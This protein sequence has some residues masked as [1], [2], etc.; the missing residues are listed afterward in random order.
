[1]S[2]STDRI[3]IKVLTKLLLQIWGFSMK[4]NRKCKLYNTL[5]LYSF[6]RLETVLVQKRKKNVNKLIYR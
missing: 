5:I 1:M 2:S 3:H 4:K 6:R